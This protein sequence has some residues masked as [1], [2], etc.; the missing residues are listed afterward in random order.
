LNS[1]ELF[2]SEVWNLTFWKACFPNKP[3]FYGSAVQVLKTLW[4]KEK[5]LV[6]SN[7]SFTP[8]VF[9]PLEEVSSIWSCRLQTPSV[10]KSLKFVIWERDTVLLLIFSYRVADY[11]DVGSDCILHAVWFWSTASI[12]NNIVINS[13]LYQMTKFETSPIS[14]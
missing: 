8:S 13:S 6:T 9:C 10:W 7:F 14:K 2:N 12:K 11:L 3:V 4:E 5:L 1:V